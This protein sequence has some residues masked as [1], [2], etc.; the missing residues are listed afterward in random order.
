MVLLP[1]SPPAV[2]RVITGLVISAL[3][4]DEFGFPAA[5]TVRTQEEEEPWTR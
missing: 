3:M 5:S 2:W 4:I 1:G